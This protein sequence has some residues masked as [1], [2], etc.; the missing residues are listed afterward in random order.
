MKKLLLM[1]FIGFTIP[2]ISSL[3]ITRSE[4]GSYSMDNISI[5]QINPQQKK[6][7]AVKEVYTCPMHP[8]VTQDKPGKCPEC[9]MNLVKKDIY[10]CPMHPKVIQDKP[11]KCPDC[12]MNLVK[13]EPVKKI[14]P[15]KK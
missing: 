2:S 6:E 10:T 1:L 12:K 3:G 14:E 11:G 5:S 8:K 15:K 13:K 9:K 7:S 4:T